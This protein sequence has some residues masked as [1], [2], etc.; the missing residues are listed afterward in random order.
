MDTCEVL[1]GHMG[2]KYPSSLVQLCLSAVTQGIPE[3]SVIYKCVVTGKCATLPVSKPQ[4]WFLA[5]ILPLK[6]IVG[7][8]HIVENNTE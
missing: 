3:Y 6:V 5:L 1:L 8:I 7:K 2:S 4:G